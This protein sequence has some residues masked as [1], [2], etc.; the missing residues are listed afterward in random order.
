MKIKKIVITLLTVAAVVFVGVKG[1]GLLESRKAEVAN[2]ALPEVASITVP[3]INATEGTLIQREKFLAKLLSDKSIKLSTKLAGFVES[4]DVTESDV[5]KKG[6]LLVKI[7]AKELA[8]TKAALQATLTAQ[9]ADYRLAK[10]IYATNVKLYNVGG[11][12]KEKLDASAVGIK[13]K[14]SMIESTKQKIVQ[15]DNQRS[16]LTIRAPFD[17]VIDRV[18]L[19]EGD[20]AAAGKPILSMSSGDKKLLFSYAPNQDRIIEKGQA[21]LLEGEEIGEIKSLYSASENGLSMAE[22]ALSKRLS[23]PIG[24]SINIE[25]ITKQAKG[26]EIPSN[27]LLHKAEGTFIMIGRDG[28]FT[29]KKVEVLMQEADKAL[30]GNC[31]NALIAVA[32][33]VRLAS[34]PAYSKVTMV[35]AKDE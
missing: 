32:S 34:L 10:S 26:C 11:L 30:I 16:Y 1:K 12:A 6:A 7:D 29:P 33:E 31:P 28:K 17:G 27:A 20:L 8:A 9:K 24:S 25:V 23:N 19:H 3:V 2:E 18:F 35:G 21:V 4:V 13:A 14:A 15:L 22:V 5:V